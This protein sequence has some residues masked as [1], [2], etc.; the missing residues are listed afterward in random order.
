MEI[1]SSLEGT[2]RVRITSASIGKTLSDISN[3]NIELRH[4]NIINDLVV[5]AV[6]K[7]RNYK[8]LNRIIEHKGDKLE[9]L[10]RTG[11]Y[12]ELI[13][14]KK[15]PILLVGILIYVL[16]ALY[17]PSRIFFIRVSGNETVSAEIVISQAE[18][19]G[20]RFGAS[21]KA[22]RS[23]QVK[24][25]L[26]SA[27]PQLQWVGVNTYGCVAQITVRERAEIPSK[28]SDNGVCSIVARRDGVIQ[29]LTATRG[30]VLCKVGQAVKA[31][32][33]L[34]SG[35]T[36]C[37]ISIKAT[38]AEAEVYAQTKHSLEVKSPLNRIVRQQQTKKKTNYSIII[39]KKLIKLYKDSGISDTGCVKIYSEQY[40]TLPGGFQL[41]IALV[42]EEQIAYTTETQIL[43]EDIVFDQTQIQS[44]EYLRNTMVAGTILSAQTTKQVAEDVLFM[45]GDYACVEMI[46]QI[47]NEEIITENE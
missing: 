30:N 22:V 15:R 2:V 45:R 26:L 14:L 36:D 40:L 17:L 9:I 4:T 31:G 18:D 8:V 24:N 19:L 43:N 3:N 23:E 13:S 5:E 32:Q 7:R 6:V 39:G 28:V 27:V 41:P 16:L 46:G 42:S 12:W 20:I 1:W 25:A 29:S 10:G 11:V 38:A 37:G 33:V 44:E 35:Y 47:Y 34:V 21:R